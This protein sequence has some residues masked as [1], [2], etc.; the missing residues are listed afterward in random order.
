MRN[1]QRIAR[2]VL[3]ATPSTTLSEA[4]ITKRIRTKNGK[5]LY[6]IPIIKNWGAGR[7]PGIM[8]A[9][10]KKQLQTVDR[11]TVELISEKPFAALIK[12]S[13]R[14]RGRPKSY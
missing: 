8:L 13:E 10:Y 11:V 5:T 6:E 2:N 12:K 7:N 9:P 14:G 1:K 4:R 3:Y